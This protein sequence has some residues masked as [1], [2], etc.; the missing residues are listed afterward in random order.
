MPE[1]RSLLHQP[2]RLPVPHGD[3]ETS[4]TSV[5]ASNSLLHDVEDIVTQADLQATVDAVVEWQLPTGMVPWYPGGHADAWN[6]TEALMA[7]ML[8]GYREEAERGFSWL[9]SIQREDGAWHQYYLEDGI[10]EDKLDANCVAYVATGVWFH[11]LTYRDR[12][13]LEEWWPMVRDATDFVLALQQPRGEIIW[14]RHA[15]ATP[16]TF[17][18]LTGSSSISHSLHCSIAIAQELGHERPNWEAGVQ[19]LK[20]VIRDDPDAFAPKHRWAMDW[21]YPVLTGAIT[22]EVARERLAH[23]REAFLTDG[24][25]VRCVSDR[26]WIT[27]AET[28]ECAM[29]HLAAGEREWAIELFTWAQRLRTDSGRYWTGIVLP[30]EVHFPGGEQS[31]YTAGAVILAADALAGKSSTAGLFAG[32]AELPPLN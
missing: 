10:E 12:S 1:F 32:N 20:R 17:A 14:A 28:C 11:W 22:G 23:R 13:V 16:F 5:S 7:L 19:K 30:D 18:L 27:A 3:P 25:G 2:R 26:P 8:G 15:D 31:T 4:R 24:W 9:Q 21:Y 29:A 6:H